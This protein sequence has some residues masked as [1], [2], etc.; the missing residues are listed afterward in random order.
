MNAITL[1]K[2]TAISLCFALLFS[3]CDKPVD[4]EPATK[5]KAIPTLN[6]KNL[7]AF[8]YTL[9]QDYMKS[10]SNLLTAFN[11]YKKSGDSFGFIQFRNHKWTPAYI[12][13]KNYYQ[14]VYKQNKA[15]I[16]NN[17][18]SPLFLAYEN[19]IYIGINLKN[20]L[21]DKNND[22][23]KEALRS[24]EEDRAIFDKVS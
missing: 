13:K 21:L 5:T 1:I 20:S 18:L 11:V 2:T 17:N 14:A 10:S 22:L 12:E 23:E 7:K 6:N 3:A 24:L 16:T 8:I 19:L 15:Y 9:S 4:S